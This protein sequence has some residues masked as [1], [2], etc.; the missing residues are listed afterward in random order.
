MNNL[1]TACGAL[2]ILVYAGLVMRYIAMPVYT[3]NLLVWLGTGGE[4]NFIETVR[5]DLGDPFEAWL[6]CIF[7]WVIWEVIS[8]VFRRGLGID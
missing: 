1:K 6:Q 4:I 8:G 7:C 3:L 5:H 2:I